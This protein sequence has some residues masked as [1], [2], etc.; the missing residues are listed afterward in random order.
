MQSAGTTLIIVLI[1]ALLLAAGVLVF[2]VAR[3]VHGVAHHR[4]RERKPAGQFRHE[5]LGVFT[6]DGDL[7]SCEF[8]RDGRE[9]RLLIGGTENAP[10][11]RLLTQAQSILGRF[12]GLE[13]RAIEFLRSREAELRTATLDFYCLEITE[14]QR[15][16]D[17][18]FEFIDPRDDSRAWRV[19]FVAGEPKHTG[20]DD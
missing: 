9:F 18:T 12:A 4:L 6:S 2:G 19:E 20:F 5:E 8:R 7:W 17:F 16:D 15:L 11:E 10:S 13:Q 1:V 3:F 14:E